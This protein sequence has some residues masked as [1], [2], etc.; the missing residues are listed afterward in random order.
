MKTE[1]AIALHVI[2]SS[3]NPADPN[4]DAQIV[5]ILGHVA[6]MAW[7]IE[8]RDQHDYN[9]MR[10]LPSV[11]TH[12]GA[13]A[14]VGIKQSELPGILLENYRNEYDEHGNAYQVRLSDY[15][16]TRYDMT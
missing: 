15:N 11:H 4:I 8:C 10:S 14:V 5:H 16:P 13:S 6:F 12:P 9:T 3:D 7:L 1:R 2:A